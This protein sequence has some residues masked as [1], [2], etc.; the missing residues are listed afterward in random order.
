MAIYKV[1]YVVIGSDHPGAIISSKVAPKR[2]DI[3]ELGND[4]FVIIEILE[5][6]PPRGEFHYYHATCQPKDIE[7]IK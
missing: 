6:M 3:V 4:S 7:P 2:G 1:S 5:L